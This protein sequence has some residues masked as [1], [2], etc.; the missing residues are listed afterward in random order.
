MAELRLHAAHP[1]DLDPETLYR[2]LQL[3]TMV[4]V[5]EQRCPYPELDGRDLEPAAEWLWAT[6]DGQLLATMRLLR[7]PDETVRIGRVAT[8]QPARSRGVAGRLVAF[9][10]QRL[11]DSVEVVLDAQSPL[12][13][14]YERFGFGRCGAEFVEDGIPHVPMRRPGQVPP[15]VTV[16][17]SG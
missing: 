12:E 8:A 11:G 15:N 13:A 1:R 7:E 10:L 6:E 4:F 3:R 2:I 5:V 14:W 9:A 16:S 17:D